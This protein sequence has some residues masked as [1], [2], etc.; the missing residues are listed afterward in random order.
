MDSK[1]LKHLEGCDEIWHAGDIGDLNVTDQL[2]KIAP[3]RAVYGNIDGSDV[4]AEFPK[5]Q[6]FT[7]A[8]LKVWI[9]HIG[10]RPPK[11][12]RGILPKIHRERPDIFV[13]GH[14]HILIAKWCKEINCLHL[15]PGAVGMYGIHKVRTIMRFSITKDGV[16]DLEIVELPR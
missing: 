10:G 2:S 16:S 12:A 7:A 6:T 3:L 11:F 13:C 1:V 15:N 5:D 14:S 4:R 9:T 8:G